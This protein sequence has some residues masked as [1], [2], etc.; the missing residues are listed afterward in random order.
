MGQPQ[1]HTCETDTATEHLVWNV[2]RLWELA[3]DLPV[4]MVPLEKVAHYLSGRWGPERP[5]GFD[6][7]RQARRIMEAD[8]ANPIIFAAEG[9]L[10]DG[11]HRVAKAYALGLPQL[12][13]V[14][15]P[16]TPEPDERRPKIPRTG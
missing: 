12:K 10:M 7:A 11:T 1:N 14:R 3:R 15:F 16:V 5:T 4:E 9:Y 13:A 6:I 2:E 8:L